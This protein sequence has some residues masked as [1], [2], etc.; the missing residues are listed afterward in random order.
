[1]LPPN[2]RK[3]HRENLAKRPRSGMKGLEHFN[4]KEHLSKGT[5]D[6]GPAWSEEDR[7][8]FHAAA[9]RRRLRNQV[10]VLVGLILVAVCA[11]WMLRHWFN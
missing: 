2:F 9:Q 6:P 10:V 11:Y 1:M 8:S 5:M 7:L 4:R 3:V